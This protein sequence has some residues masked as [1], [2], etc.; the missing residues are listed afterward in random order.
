VR[1]NFYL[2]EEIN[3]IYSHKDIVGN[4][5]AGMD[6]IEDVLKTDGPGGEEG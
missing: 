1:R 6:L 2:R 3:L 5:E 4:S